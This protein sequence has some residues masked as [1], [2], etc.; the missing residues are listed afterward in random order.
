MRTFEEILRDAATSC[1]R[2]FYAGYKN[3]YKEVIE[4]ATKIYIAQMKN[5]N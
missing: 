2:V 4:A 5:N 3:N 1:N